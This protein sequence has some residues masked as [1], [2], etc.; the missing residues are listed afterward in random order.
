MFSGKFKY[1]SNFIFFLEFRKFKDV[2]VI[3]WR[4]DSWISHMGFVVLNFQFCRFINSH[5]LSFC[6][7]W[8]FYVNHISPLC[9]DLSCNQEREL[10]C[11][12]KLNT[13]WFSLCSLAWVVWLIILKDP[14]FLP[15][16]M[17]ARLNNF[18]LFMLGNLQGQHKVDQ[19]KYVW[20]MEVTV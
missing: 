8:S 6:N 16:Y 9:V 4:G 20:V 1:I 10:G 13:I 11:N 2:I 19:Q 5:G 18:G 12:A 3:P 15:I 7:Q 17:E 14:W